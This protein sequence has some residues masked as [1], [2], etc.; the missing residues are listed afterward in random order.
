MV[1]NDVHNRVPLYPLLTGRA[2]SSIDFA[3]FNGDVLNDPQTERELTD[4]L[5]VPMAWFASRSIP[6]FFLRGN[7]ETRGAFARRLKDY[8]HRGTVGL[9]AA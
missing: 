1:F 4:H 7:H 5:L 8:V 9:A 6:C 3:V 2:G